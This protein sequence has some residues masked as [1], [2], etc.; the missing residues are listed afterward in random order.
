MATNNEATSLVGSGSKETKKSKTARCYYCFM[1][2]VF[3][4][5]FLDSV[6]SLGIFG[7]IQAKVNNLRTSNNTCILFGTLATS[8]EDS[9]VCIDLPNVGSCAFVLWGLVSVTIV[10]FVWL[11]YF[12]VLF[13]LNTIV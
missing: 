3:L 1:L 6:I 2:V 9:V 5:L 4:V 10:A 13:V 8:T 12:I 7:A 11:I